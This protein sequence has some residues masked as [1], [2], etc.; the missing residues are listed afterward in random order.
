[1]P[2]SP[3]AFADFDPIVLCTASRRVQGAEASEGGYVQGAADDHEAWSH[4]LT[5][6]IFWKHK[7][8]LMSTSEEDTPD[9][10]AKLVEK[11]AQSR[12]TST[13]TLIKPTTHLHISPSQSTDLTGFDVVISCTPK[14]LDSTSLKDAKIK[15]YLHLKC[16]QIAKLGSRDLRAEMPFLPSFLSSLP[17]FP[18]PPKILVCCLTGKDLSVGTA[19]AIL[20]LF[21]SETGAISLD[22]RK[23]ATEVDKNF[24]KQRLSWITTSNPALNPSR[25][26]LQS[27]NAVLLS[28]GQ[29]PKSMNLPIRVLPCAYQPPAP[30]TD[31]SSP[32]LQAKIFNSL[33]GKPWT[34]HRKLTS[35]LPTHPC[36][37]V[38]GAATFTRCTLSRPDFPRTLLYAEEGEFI[39]DTGLRFTAK[40]KYVYQLFT[41]ASE[42]NTGGDVDDEGGELAVKFFANEDLPSSQ[43][44]QDG[45]GAGGEGIGRLFVEMGELTPSSSIPER[46]SGGAMEAKNKEQHLCAEDLY[47]ASW[48]F[49]KGMTTGEGEMWWEVKYDVKG[50]KKDY[51]SWTRYERA[52]KEGVA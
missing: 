52:S 51:M 14:S 18:S 32:R 48:R 34:F 22:N 30:C 44:V 6:P 49:S 27:V 50:P 38:N 37:T 45:V 4:G 28:A 47:S 20:C 16:N 36:G 12:T 21:T 11:E 2:D 33:S 8:V 25:A 43:Q 26:T 29:D 9:L 46:D 42:T 39:A 13:A 5:P 24:I 1:L 7:D 19:L 40:R 15:H 31:K 23:S 41:T 3:P 10:V 17:A 35:T